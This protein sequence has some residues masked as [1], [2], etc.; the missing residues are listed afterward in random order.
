MVY[1]KFRFNWTSC[2]YVCKTWQPY[3]DKII[4]NTRIVVAIALTNDY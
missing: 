4:N 2:I 3:P 1:L